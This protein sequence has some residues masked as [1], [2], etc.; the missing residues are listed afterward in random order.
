VKAEQATAVLDG[1][2]A[3]IDTRAGQIKSL[4]SK[5]WIIQDFRIDGG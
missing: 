2:N 1:D 5:P 3:V 4:K